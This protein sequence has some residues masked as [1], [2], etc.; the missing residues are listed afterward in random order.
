[1]KNDRKYSKESKEQLQ[2]QR[3]TFK[4]DDSCRI[5]KPNER[6]DKI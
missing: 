2:Q 5:I 6:D 1:M 4:T 3:K